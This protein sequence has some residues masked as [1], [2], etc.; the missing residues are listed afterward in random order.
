MNSHIYYNLDEYGNVVS[1]TKGK[2]VLAQMRELMWVYFPD[3]LLMEWR[4]QPKDSKDAVIA[5]LHREFSNLEGYCFDKHQMISHMNRTWIVRWS[6]GEA[7]QEWRWILRAQNLL[8]Y[9]RMIGDKFWTSVKLC[10]T[11]GINNKKPI[12]YNRKQQAFRIWAEVARIGYMQ[13]L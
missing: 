13:N 4:R 5:I 10:Q 8:D 6:P 1:N 3:D 11:G 9:H 12:A 7:P 2:R